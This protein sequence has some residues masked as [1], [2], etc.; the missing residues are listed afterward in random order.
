MSER[1]S[2]LGFAYRAHKNGRVTILHKGKVAATLKG[3]RAA[4]FLRRA[5]QGS[6]AA[7]QQLMARWTGNYKH[8]NE[9]TTINPSY[10]KFPEV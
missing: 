3:D 4:K 6:F 7:G 2:D 9:R 5:Q 1:E 8:G 10:V